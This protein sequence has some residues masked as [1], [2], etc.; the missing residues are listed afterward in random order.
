VVEEGG[1]PGESHRPW[2]SK[3][4]TLSHAAAIHELD[5]PQI[6]FFLQK[7]AKIGAYE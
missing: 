6:I 7:T 2:A 4:S 5:N 3:W 1:V